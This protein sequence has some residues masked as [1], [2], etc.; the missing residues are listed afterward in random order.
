MAHLILSKES[1]HNAGDLGSIS[2]GKIPW[3]K[4]RLPTPVFWP[5]EFHGLYSPWGHRATQQNDFHFPRTSWSCGC[6]PRVVCQSHCEELQPFHFCG[7]P[8]TFFFPSYLVSRSCPL[9]CN[10]MN[11]TTPGL[12]VLHCLPE[13]AQTHVYCGEGN[14]NPL[15][16]SCLENPR[17]GG[18]WWAAVYGVAQSRTRL[19]RLSSSSSSI[20][21]ESVMP[22][23][24]LILCRPP[25]LSP[26]IF[27]SIR[28]L[29]R[30][31]ALRIRWPELQHQPLQWVLT[32]LFSPR[33]STN[34]RERGSASRTWIR[35][36][37]RRGGGWRRRA[38]AQ[39]R[40]AAPARA[41]TPHPPTRTARAR[42]QGRCSPPTPPTA[43]PPRASSS[44]RT[45][46]LGAWGPSQAPPPLQR[47]RPAWR[48]GSVSQK[49]H[50]AG[51]VGICPVGNFSRKTQLVILVQKHRAENG[52]V[53]R[54]H[55]ML[56]V[57]WV[58]PARLLL[59]GH[60]CLSIWV[61]TSEV[62]A[63]DSKSQGHQR[64]ASKS[65]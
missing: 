28:V 59:R 9:L 38:R 33:P 58:T 7:I 37:W 25:L 24:H 23:S 47:P 45:E 51:S 48:P 40:A 18:A 36:R 54:A 41:R 60:Q 61:A 27:P 26:S 65:S 55:G 2:V 20:P 57:T 14:G 13:F 1:A 63:A 16:C 4:E 22:S 12:P 30:E 32:L 17:D 5:G 64:S 34:T 39:R 56:L 43:A 8:L 11:C 31:S 19:T 29:A 50:P 15:Q 44:S 49:P 6:W 53:S 62:W 35:P 10:R 42:P 3:R 52:T 46:R 21:F